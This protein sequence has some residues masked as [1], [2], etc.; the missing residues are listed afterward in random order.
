MRLVDDVPEQDGLAGHH[1][2]VQ[3]GKDLDQ[4]LRHLS[5]DTDLVAHEPS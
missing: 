2:V 4:R 5:V 3:L 1:D